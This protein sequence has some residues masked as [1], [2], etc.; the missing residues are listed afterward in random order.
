[1]IVRFFVIQYSCEG[2]IFPLEEVKVNPDQQGEGKMK[3]RTDFTLIELLVVIAIIAIL[4]GML[5]P[6]L[7]KARAAGQGASCLS[8]LKQHGMGLMMYTSISDDYLPTS[9]VYKNGTSSGLGYIHW[10]ALITGRTDAKEP[11]EDKSF[12]CPGLIILDPAQG[13]NG[14]WLPSKPALDAQAKYMGYTGNEIFM[15][16]KKLANMPDVNLVKIIKA[17]APSSEILVTEYTE[18]AKL[19]DD[20]S[21][22]GGQAIKSHRPTSGISDGGSVWGGGEAGPIGRPQMITMAQ[23][24]ATFEGN[25][26]SHHIGYVGYNRHNGRANYAFADGHAEGKR[27][28]ETLSPN[29]FLW[30]KKVYCS[31]GMPDITQ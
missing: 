8:N 28:E 5:L 18:K 29:N 26:A 4:A 6:A 21:A 3:K 17:M 7:G 27:I 19:I 2:K 25:S 11:F 15:P 14:G 24:K 22:S 12:S 1:L 30:G 23:A 16:R 31:P 10:S 20:S 9:Y 13:G